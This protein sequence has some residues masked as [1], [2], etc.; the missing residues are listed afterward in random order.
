MKIAIVVQRYGSDINGGAELHAR[1]V[2]ERLS[3]H[4]DVR[5]LTT[6]ARDYVTWRNELRAG[7]EQV[8]GVTVERFEVDVERA[9]DDF[10]RRSERVFN[11]LHSIADELRWLDSEGPASRALISRIRRATEFDFVLLFSVRYYHAYHGARAASRRAVLV[12]TAEREPSIGLRIFQPIFRGVRAIMYNSFEER[13]TISALSSNDHVPGVVVGVGS[14]VPD[15]IEP[16]RVRAKFGLRD[17]FIV[18]VGRID[19]N[20]GCT[21][22]FDNFLSYLERSTRALDLVV[23]GNAVMPIPSHP[24]IRHLG[25]VSDEDKFDAMAAAEVLVMPSYYESLS[26]VALEAWALARPVLA[27]AH[28]DVL[29]GQCVRSNAGLY[30]EDPLE[31]G[32]AL[33]LLLDNPS[34][35]ARLGANGRGYFLQHYS[36]PVIERKYLDMFERLTATPP[37]HEME[38]L[39]GWLERRARSAPPA[40]EVVNAVPRGAALRQERSA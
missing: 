22:L 21:E 38:P 17:R 1:Y 10:G 2:A 31:F 14:D 15:R 26:M 13:A 18:Y 6:C 19:A 29:V 30:Y 27:N 5:V 16:D 40:S 9:L 33:D 28:C 7:V 39:P 34:L 32:A 24:R 8:N 4:A 35:A 37:A 11:Q 25:F 23:I 36:W 3:R 12:P 20:K